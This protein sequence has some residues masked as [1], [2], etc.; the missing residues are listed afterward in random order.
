[1]SWDLGVSEAAQ[2]T[3]EKHSETPVKLD[4]MWKKKQQINKSLTSACQQ[5]RRHRKLSNKQKG[6]WNIMEKEVLRKSL[7]TYWEVLHLF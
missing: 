1:M 5:E 7:K 3:E 6:C 2:K 4:L